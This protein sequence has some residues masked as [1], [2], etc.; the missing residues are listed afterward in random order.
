MQQTLDISGGT[1]SV[2]YFI[3]AG[4]FTQNGNLK[5]FSDPRNKGV[6]NN[7]FYHRFNFR[8]NLDIQATKS[9][10]LRID[11]SGRLGQIN[12]PLFYPNQTATSPMSEIYNYGILTPY[13][14]VY[15]VQ[16]FHKGTVAN[17]TGAT[18]V[19]REGE[20]LTLRVKTGNGPGNKYTSAKIIV[21]LL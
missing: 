1:E 5:N 21:E 3:S 2:K 20:V 9:L 17:I 11:V 10:K 13:A 12:E 4:A 14:A 6:E 15:E 16:L 18:I 19:K 8:S 7:Y